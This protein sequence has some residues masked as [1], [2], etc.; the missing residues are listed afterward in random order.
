M[1]ESWN[2]KKLLAIVVLGF[3]WSGSANSETI[4]LKCITKYQDTK[5]P[6]DLSSKDPIYINIDTNKTDSIITDNHIS[7]YAAMALTPDTKFLS[8]EVINRYDGSRYLN[9]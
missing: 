4:R 7:Y 2:M 8:Y 3:L 6:D 5:H 9:Q 1:L